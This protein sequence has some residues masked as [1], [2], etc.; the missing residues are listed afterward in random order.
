MLITNYFT[1]HFIGDAFATIAPPMD[2][3]NEWLANNAPICMGKNVW[4]DGGGANLDIV[5]ISL[6]ATFANFDG[7]QP[8]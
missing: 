8:A 1:G 5:T 3:L 4:M 2:W 7:G 6:I